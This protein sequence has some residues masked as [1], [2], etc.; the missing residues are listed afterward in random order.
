MVVRADWHRQVQEGIRRLSGLLRQDA[1]QQMVGW[2]CGAENRD[3][4]RLSPCD[5]SF[6]GATPYFGSVSDEGG[7]EGQLDRSI[8]HYL[9]NHDLPETGD[10]VE[11]QD[12]GT[13]RSVA[14]APVGDC[15]VPSGWDEIRF[16]GFYDALCS[17]RSPRGACD[18]QLDIE[19]MGFSQE[20]MYNGSQD[21]QPR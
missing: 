19:Y 21:A 8:G 14:E 1:D 15:G 12:G 20:I 5:V 13:D 9:Y 4:G 11:W 16:E 18:E 17:T 10:S 7:D 2:L 6:F 3:N